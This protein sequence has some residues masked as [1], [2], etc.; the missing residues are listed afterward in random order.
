MVHVCSHKEMFNSLVI[1]EEGVII[2]V[3]GSTC[4][5][6]SVGTVNVTKRDEM[7]YALE[8]VRYVPEAWYNF[9]FHRD[10]R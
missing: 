2:M 6:I 10:A 7:V 9:I 5:I 4:E 1:K 8:V 3:D